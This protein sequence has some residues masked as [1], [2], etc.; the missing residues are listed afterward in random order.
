MLRNACREGGQ[1]WTV[2]AGALALVACTAQTRV[3]SDCLTDRICEEVTEMARPPVEG[4]RVQRIPNPPPPTGAIQRVD[5]LLIVDGDDSMAAQR[6]AFAAFM[7]SL[8]SA[9]RSGNADQAGGREFYPIRDIHIG[10]LAS[11][12]ATG[13]APE[14][15]KSDD[16]VLRSLEVCGD[17]SGQPFVAIGSA[18]DVGSRAALVSCGIALITETCAYSEP[19]EAG[20]KALWPE[21][22]QSV[23][24]GGAHGSGENA[25]FLRDDALLVII[26]LTNRDDCS[27]ADPL[28]VVDPEVLLTRLGS[29][30]LHPSPVGPGRSQDSEGSDLIL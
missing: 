13:A 30:G 9:I 16:G 26:V 15:C 11:D 21:D 7:P 28:Q 27:I 1:G 22:D 29:E 18:D 4:D 6:S 23:V 12:L 14:G 20:I 3:G 25:E 24:V 2:T 5:L 10:I 17:T 19:L 8:L